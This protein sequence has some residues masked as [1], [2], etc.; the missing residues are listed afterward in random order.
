[1]F[2]ERV[3]SMCFFSVLDGGEIFLYLMMF[4]CRKNLVVLTRS[5]TSL[6][7]QKLC[8]DIRERVDYS[9]RSESRMISK[10]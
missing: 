10:H 2:N 5:I 4:I 6:Q 9:L 7:V 1:M 8:D 3:F